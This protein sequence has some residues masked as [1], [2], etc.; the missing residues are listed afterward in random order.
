MKEIYSLEQ[1]TRKLDKGFNRWRSY[2]LKTYNNTNQYFSTKSYL[3]ERK[4]IG[5]KPH[6]LTFIAFDRLGNI[7]NGM[8]LSF[9]HSIT[10][11]QEPAV[12]SRL[13]IAATNRQD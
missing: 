5:P 9:D 2:P 12:N 10:R 7:R 13:D 11:N 1:C 8:F 4:N 3:L 6:T